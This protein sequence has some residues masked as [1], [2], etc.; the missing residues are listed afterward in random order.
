M[1]QSAVKDGLGNLTT[2]EYDGPNAYETTADCTGANQW[3]DRCLKSMKGLVS[4]HSE[5][6]YY[7]LA[8]TSIE[9]TYDYKYVNARMN[10]TGH[11]WLG[12][13]QRSVVETSGEV[14]TRVTTDFE[15]PARFTPT[16][17]A[18]DPAAPLTPPYLYP[19]AGLTKTVTVDRGYIAGASAVA[20]PLEEELHSRRSVVSN[21]W[22][23][24][25]SDDARPFPI[26]KSATT[27]TFSRSAD[28]APFSENG[29]LR[30][31][32]TVSYSS[33]D[34]Y[35]NHKREVST[36]GPAT[37]Y[38]PLEHTETVTDFS[39]FPSTWLISNVDKLTVTSYRDAASLARTQV[40]DPGYD[41]L[42]QLTSVLRDPGGEAQLT[43]SRPTALL[44]CSKASSRRTIC[45]GSR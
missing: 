13:D 23:V 32:C 30:T 19:L 44:P 29:Q 12:F 1:L 27:E 11:G 35:G 45:P 39:P 26:L 14:F 6:A 41:S 28:A 40:Y 8:E 38:F 31:S 15:P 7:G 16:G 37:A 4:R 34:G 3:P 25:L 5:G 24:K 33:F 36:C 43:V 2:I 22:G 9:R 17:V 18:V 42:G 20:S 21:A 10:V